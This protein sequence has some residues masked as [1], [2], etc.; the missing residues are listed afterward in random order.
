MSPSTDGHLLDTSVQHA[1]L[2]DGRKSPSKD[3]E[4]NL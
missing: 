1:D 3:F 2:R 4:Q